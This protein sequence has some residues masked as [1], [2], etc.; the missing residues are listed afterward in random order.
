MTNQKHQNISINASEGLWQWLTEQQVSLAFTTYQTNRLF[1]VGCKPEGRLNVNERV[2]DKP[3]GLYAHE[4]SLYMATRYQLWQLENRLAPGETYQG[5]DRLY[6]PCQS[7][8]TGD[9]NVHDVVLDRNKQLLFINTDFSCLAALRPGYSFEPLWQPPFI[10]KLAAEDRCHLNGLALRGGE[11]TYVTACSSTNDGAG[12]RNHRLDGGIVMHI[13]SNEIIATG[14]SMPHS[15][16]WYQGKLWLLNA[17]TGD[18]GFLDGERF[19]PVTFCPGFVRGLAFVGHYALVGL[20]KLRSKAFGGLVLEQRLLELGLTSQCGLQVIDLNTGQVVHSLMMESIVEELFDV[21][22]LPKVST[23]TSVGFMEE[24]INRLVN[25]PGSKG[26]V[27]TKPTVSRPGATDIQVAGLPRQSQLAQ[28]EPSQ[29]NYQ[30]VYH[31]TPENLAPYDAL[32]YPSLQKRWQTQPQ[33]GELHAVS[34]SVDGQMVGFIV[35]EQQPDSQG[36]TPTFAVLS[37][38]VLPTYRHQGI[39]TVLKQRLQQAFSAVQ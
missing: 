25:F 17:G 24:D 20:S 39:A 18:L 1:L 32:T 13:P 15:P 28:V 26:L 37:L 11:P 22:I 5:H 23:P 7:H 36:Q 30:R 27:T 2:F 8:T 19:V 35:A 14:L 12:W 29:V 33:Q 9:L 3:M 4:N 16:R 6:I 21:V 38:F 34:A 31:L 10:T